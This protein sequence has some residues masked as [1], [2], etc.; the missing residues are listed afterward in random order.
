M[1]RQ[2]RTLRTA[3]LCLAAAAALVGVV[4]SLASAVA[5]PRTVPAQIVYEHGNRPGD[6][7]NC[8]AVVFAQW[9]HVPASSVV[10]RY[11]YNGV[12]TSKASAFPFDNE[13]QL[14]KLYVAPVGYDRVNLGG[15]W[16]DGPIANDCSDKEPKQRALLG[17]EATVEITGEGPKL[18]VV[19]KARKSKDLV[20]GDPQTYVKATV[21]NVGDVAAE[22]VALDSQATVER[23]PA[24]RRICDA[25][26]K[27][28]DGKQARTSSLAPGASLSGDYTFDNLRGD[29]VRITIGAT[30]TDADAR[31]SVVVDLP[32]DAYIVG[33]LRGVPAFTVPGLWTTQWPTEDAARLM[34]RFRIRAVGGRKTLSDV[35]SGLSY[36]IKVPTKLLGRYRVAG[37][38]ADIEK[39]QLD[40]EPASRMVKVGPGESV[41]ADFTFGY[42]CGVKPPGMSF[43]PKN[44]K[45]RSN[46]MGVEY[47]CRSRRVMVRVALWNAVVE[48]GGTG[49]TSIHSDQD[50]THELHCL[51]GA[52]FVWPRNWSE[53]TR[54]AYPEWTMAEF[55]SPFDRQ[56]AP[57]KLRKGG[58]FGGSVPL[59]G[60][61][62]LGQFKVDGAFTSPAIA[63][64]SVVNTVCPVDESAQDIKHRR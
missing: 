59:A 52:S 34:A 1:G 9:E 18:K 56:P 42:D 54:A 8:S 32:D 7:G 41:R 4:A 53:V 16:A 13:Y 60:A 38:P 51:K 39:R 23:I 57:F 62:V 31:G 15:S 64:A 61:D 45:Y 55:P 27:Q 17:T 2:R 21:T 12:A 10:V 63:R 25:S 29:K 30:A 6:P 46:I 26:L 47:Q 33:T 5:K 36:R 14:V 48:D 50:G 40:L 43:V 28:A 11:S 58:G 19:L 22:N 35:A 3:A 20:D 37:L 44:G 49:D 24:C